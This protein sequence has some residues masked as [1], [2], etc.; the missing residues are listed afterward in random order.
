[1][2]QLN[3]A[4]SDPRATEIRL[5]RVYNL[6]PFMLVAFNFYFRELRKSVYTTGASISFDT[7]R[8][9]IVQKWINFLVWFFFLIKLLWMTFCVSKFHA[10]GS[11]GFGEIP[12]LRVRCHNEGGSVWLWHLDLTFSNCS[13][14]KTL[15]ATYVGLV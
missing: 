11:I 2:F 13:Y 8:T 6:G 10:T 5:K 7:K 15:W 1:M 4:I 12:S 9:Y 3:C 14:F